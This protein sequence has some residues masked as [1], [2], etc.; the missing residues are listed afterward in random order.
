MADAR[1][2]GGRGTAAVHGD[3]SAVLLVRVWVEDDAWTLR[4]RLTSRDTS[5]G[6][7]GT[8]ETTVALAAS[9]DDVLDAVRAWLDAVR[10]DASLEEGV[11][12]LVMVLF[13]LGETLDSRG[14]IREGALDTLR[15]LA[16]LRRGSHPAVVLGLLSDTR[17]PTDPAD[18]VA[19]RAEYHQLL[20][21]LGIRGFF[22]PLER[23]VTLSAEVGVRKPAPAAF[24]A[25]VTR[26]GPALR[27]ADVVFVTE[28]AEH[29]RAARRLGMTGVQVRPAGAP[30]AAGAELPAVLTVVHDLLAAVPDDGVTQR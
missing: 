15:A 10:R 19:V 1:G 6:G 21:D 23:R 18:V 24:R 16:G 7:A 12:R 22:E 20:D 8:P 9:P 25:A 26:A 30:G 14:A 3:R 4:G 17:V 28:N 11:D 29:V 5:P 2:I 13:V 27:Y